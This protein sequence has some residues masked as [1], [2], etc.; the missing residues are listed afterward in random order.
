LCKSGHFTGIEDC[1]IIA[2]RYLEVA[3]F[4]VEKQVRFL[5]ENFKQRKTLETGTPIGEDIS[6]ERRVEPRLTGL[7][8]QLQGQTK[9]SH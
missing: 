4:Y 3:A 9:E 2:A 7:V 1:N 5:L 6:F 8:Q